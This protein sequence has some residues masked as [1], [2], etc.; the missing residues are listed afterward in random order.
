[1]AQSYLANYSEVAAYHWQWVIFIWLK[2]ER[3]FLSVAIFIFSIAP[4]TGLWVH[5]IPLELQSLWNW[6][7]ILMPFLLGEM[8]GKANQSQ[9][10]PQREAIA[11]IK[12][13]RWMLNTRWSGYLSDCF[14]ETPNAA[15][16]PVLSYGLPPV[17]MSNWSKCALWFLPQY[18]AR[19]SAA[20]LL[21]GD[22]SPR[23]AGSP[24]H[25]RE[26]YLDAPGGAGSGQL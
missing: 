11:L 14:H 17:S 2:S 10:A 19:R 3:Q 16:H 13:I 25:D 22:T 18:W 20:S 23:A 15:S 21:E 12:L 4:F 1:M 24:C 26:V 7:F 8:K 9:F 6:I 5:C